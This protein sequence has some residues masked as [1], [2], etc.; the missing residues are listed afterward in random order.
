MLDF[1]LFQI[2]WCVWFERHAIVTHA[3]LAMSTHLLVSPSCNLAIL[4]VKPII[5]LGLHHNI[6]W[7]LDGSVRIGLCERCNRDIFGGGNNGAIQS[8]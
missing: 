2:L 1:L 8:I 7:A 4:F 6:P 5:E 3:F